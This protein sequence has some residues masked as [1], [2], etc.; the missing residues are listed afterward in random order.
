MSKLKTAPSPTLDDDDDQPVL[1]FVADDKVTV[2]PEYQTEGA[3]GFDIAVCKSETIP[4]WQHRILPTGLRFE[5]PRGYELQIRTRSGIAAKKGGFILN[6]PGTVDWDYRGELFLII[7]N[8][9]IAPLRLEAGDRVAQGV[10]AP[11]TRGLLKQVKIAD[12]S[13]TARGEGRFGSTGT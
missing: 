3:A 5:V 2:F 10:L 6:S 8:L 7:A 12:L 1:K 11:V 4:R 9:G 13:Q